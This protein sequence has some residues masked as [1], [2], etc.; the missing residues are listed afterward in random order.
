[1]LPFHEFFPGDRVYTFIQT[2][3][4]PLPAG[5][6]AILEY[7]CDNLLC[8]CN[9][10]VFSIEHLNEVGKLQNKVVSAIYYAWKEKNH[11]PIF[12]IE[13]STLKLPFADA[14]LQLFRKLVLGSQEYATSLEEHYQMIRSFPDATM[15]HVSPRIERN[16]P[17]P[18][19]SGKKYKKCCI[20]KDLSNK[21]TN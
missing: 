15:I 1:M 2:D 9:A 4:D 16:A 7:Y 17:C 21:S 20:N 5:K 12:E 10:G 19:G 3:D 8:D 6:Y 13:P 14:G 18:C 11:S